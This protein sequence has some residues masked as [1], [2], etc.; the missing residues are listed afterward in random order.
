RP[1]FGAA[2]APDTARQLLDRFVTLLAQSGVPVQ[3]GEFGADMKVVVEND[4]PVT[5]VLEVQ[6]PI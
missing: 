5:L 4:G 1:N 2:A 3:T 6:N